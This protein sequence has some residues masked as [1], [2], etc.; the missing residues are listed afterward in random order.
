MT[1]SFVFNPSLVPY[2]YIL[3][4]LGVLGVLIAFLIW[5]M[6]IKEP[7]PELKEELEK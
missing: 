3:G 6:T 2:I 1:S 7:L 5:I 4:L